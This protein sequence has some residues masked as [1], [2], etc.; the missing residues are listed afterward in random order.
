M[1]KK[2]LKDCWRK[3]LFGNKRNSETYIKYLRSLGM[4]IGSNTVI[5]DPVNTLID[6]T[7]PWLIS[8]GDNVKITYGTI[9]LTHGYDWSVLKGVYGDVLGSSGGGIDRR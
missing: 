7:R 9:I 1:L 4:K 6:E 8:I 5:Y 3:L 2:V